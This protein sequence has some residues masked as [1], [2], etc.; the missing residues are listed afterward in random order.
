MKEELATDTFVYRMVFDE[1]HSNKALGHLT[2]QYLQFEFDLNGQKV[3]RYYHPMSKVFDEGYIDLL[4][5]VYLR[6]FQHQGGL[7][8]Q[9]ID[10]MKP[11]QGGISI[12]GIG[13]DIAYLE[14]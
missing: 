11:G 1:Q 9:F 4:I 3:Q 14:N 8:T 2:C 12:T 6:S 10:S 13:G 7:A 5:K